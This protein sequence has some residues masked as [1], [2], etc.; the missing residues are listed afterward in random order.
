VQT[1]LE[2]DVRSLKAVKDLS[3]FRRFLTLL[4]TRTGQLLNKTDLAAPLGVSVPTLTEWISVLEATGH[5][6]LVP[7]F[8]E[9]L[10]KRLVK[11]PKLYW[12]DSGLVCF[13][14]GIETE[15]QLQRSPFLGPIFETF[16]A[17]EIVKNQLNSGR[18]K[19]LYFFRDHQG[20]EV[21]FMTAG[22]G[23]RLCLVE[24]KWTKTIQPR[25]AGP[26]RKLKKTLGERTADA[27]IVHPAAASG[28]RL[29]SVAPGVRAVTLEE[30][31]QGFPD[32][33]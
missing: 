19:E 21:D 31:L 30:F 17:A 29:A 32:K 33:V 5:I 7:P 22:A 15:R 27:L 25:L 23:G 26:L 11:S 13:L 10:G 6:L 16:L 9:N 28:P 12:M 3:T 1:Y 14:L 18:S 8:Y 24:A 4:A 2:R 20:L